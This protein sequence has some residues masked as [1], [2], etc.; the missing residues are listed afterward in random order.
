MYVDEKCECGKKNS[1][2]NVL[3]NQHPLSKS[4]I[5]SVFIMFLGL[6]RLPMYLHVNNSLH[7]FLFVFA[8]CQYGAKQPVQPIFTII[9]VGV[10]V[11]QQ[12]M[13]AN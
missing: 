7:I 3:F 10:H 9:G 2:E 13:I 8:L 6:C 1:Y 11:V 4:I 12:M 5:N